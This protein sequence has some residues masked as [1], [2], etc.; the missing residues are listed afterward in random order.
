MI[1]LYDKV[2]GAPVGKI[3]KEQLHFL[4]DQLQDDT[5]D[6]NEYYMNAAT[7]DMIEESGAAPELMTVL[8]QAL[9]GRDDMVL[10]S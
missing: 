9:A 1:E 3:T 4:A 7:L 2:S 8:R 10:T 5:P 6:V